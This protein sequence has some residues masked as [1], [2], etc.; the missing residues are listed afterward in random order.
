M[1]PNS[2]GDVI[3]LPANAKLATISGT[4]VGTNHRKH[5]CLAKLRLVAPN[6]RNSGLRRSLDSLGNYSVAVPLGKYE[7]MLPDAYFQNGEN[8]YDGRPAKSCYRFSQNN[9]R[10]NGAKDHDRIFTY[11]GPGPG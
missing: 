6:I 2:L 4:L 10:N 3:L 1:N 5:T 8:V 9:R 7:I 11:A